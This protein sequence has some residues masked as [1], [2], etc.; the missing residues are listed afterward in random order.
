[1]KCYVP[2]LFVLS[3]GPGLWN[4]DLKAGEDRAVYKWKAQLLDHIQCE[5]RQWRRSN[6]ALNLSV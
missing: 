4:G 6:S 1:M 2:N 5:G 3:S